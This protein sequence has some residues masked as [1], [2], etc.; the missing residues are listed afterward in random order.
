MPFPGN[1]TK[2][3]YQVPKMYESVLFVGLHRLFDWDFD[4]AGRGKLIVAV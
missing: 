4:Q 2:F 3:C 1:Q